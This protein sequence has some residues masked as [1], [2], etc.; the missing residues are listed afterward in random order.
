MTSRYWQ[1]L[2]A[3][4]MLLLV[5]VV[6]YFTLTLITGCVIPA[7]QEA[8][9]MDGFDWWY[10]VFFA[11]GLLAGWFFIPTPR[12]ILRKMKG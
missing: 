9:D 11:I 5:L 7:P 12:A 2:R 8:R 1:R 3:C 10:V 6:L 4:L